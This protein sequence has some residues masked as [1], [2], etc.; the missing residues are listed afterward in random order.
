MERV[1]W[2]TS[3]RSVVK[4]LPRCNVLIIQV[5]SSEVLSVSDNSPDSRDDCLRIYVQDETAN[6]YD[7]LPLLCYFT[8]PNKMKLTRLATP[9]CRIV[10]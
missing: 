6:N 1:Y 5:G 9:S 7:V 8:F 2:T 3:K 10:V 4:K